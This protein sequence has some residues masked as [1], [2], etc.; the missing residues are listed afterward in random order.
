MAGDYEN[1]KDNT[2]S[3]LFVCTG[4]ICRS[5]MAEAVFEHLVRQVGLDDQIDVDSAGTADYHVGRRAHPG[6]LR[7]L[8]KNGIF[9]DG[10]ARHL[11]RDDLRQFDYIIAMD[12]ENL[13]DV[14]ALGETDATVA[15]LL[16]FA[17]EQPE[18]EVPDPYYSGRFE[19]V[20]PLVLAGGKGLLARIRK[21]HN[22]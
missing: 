18:R 13:D 20:Y 21:D 17:P 10:R 12:N 22:L 15:R 4:N 2:V 14:Q 1:V 3:V 5:P 6:T 16:D 19:E 7:V 11:T 9:H 8:E